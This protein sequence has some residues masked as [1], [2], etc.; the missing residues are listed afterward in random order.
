MAWCRQATS[1]YL[2]QCGPRSLS[3]YGVTWPWWVNPPCGERPPALK[4]H[5]IQWLLYTGF[6]GCYQWQ[7]PSNPGTILLW[8]IK[9]Y[10]N[11]KQNPPSEQLV[12]EVIKQKCFISSSIISCQHLSQQLGFEYQHIMAKT[13]INYSLWPSLIQAH[14][15]TFTHFLFLFFKVILFSKHFI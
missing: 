12:P 5:T 4:D 13:N 14:E 9:C 15:F 8:Y 10:V 3:P 2:S 7:S 6:T 11:K 1:H